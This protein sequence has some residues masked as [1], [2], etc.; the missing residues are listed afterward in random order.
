MFKLNGSTNFSEI[1]ITVKC[2]RYCAWEV[3][4]LFGKHVVIFFQNAS[5]LLFVLFNF[6]GVFHCYFKYL[7]GCFTSRT[8]IILQLHSLCGCWILVS[9]SMTQPSVELLLRTDC[10]STW[11]RGS[12]RRSAFPL[13]NPKPKNREMNSVQCH[14][15]P[16]VFTWYWPGPGSTN[17]HIWIM[18]SDHGSIYKSV[19]VISI[20]PVPWWNLNMQIRTC[21]ITGQGQRCRP[22]LEAPLMFK[23]KVMWQMENVK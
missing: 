21:C 22:V 23:V 13:S 3:R 10:G 6:N 2:G 20:L 4:H 9:R 19:F 1:T 8:Y 7:G 14:P 5:Y 15:P 16:A 18:S 12:N 11:A 17:G